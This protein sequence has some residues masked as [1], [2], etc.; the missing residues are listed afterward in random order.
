[1]ATATPQ[2]TTSDRFGPVTAA[3]RPAPWGRLLTAVESYAVTVASMVLAATERIEVAIACDARQE[4]ELLHAQRAVARIIA[5]GHG[6]SVNEARV[7]Q[8]HFCRAE[9]ADRPRD[10]HALVMRVLLRAASRALGH[11]GRTIEQ[12]ATGRSRMEATT[13]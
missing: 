13:S 2:S 9:T 4:A 11:I 7:A 10:E 8:A 1:M 3:A 5:I 12:A 6:P